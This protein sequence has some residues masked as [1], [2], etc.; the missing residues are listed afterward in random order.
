MSDDKVDD[1]LAAGAIFDWITPLAHWLGGYNHLY[2]ATGDFAEA[3]A[4]RDVLRARGVAA[5]LEG[6]VFSG[7]R[8]TT[9]TK[10]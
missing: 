1:L 6:N 8:V 3:V 5:R 4:A 9:K 2:L 7:Y 10:I